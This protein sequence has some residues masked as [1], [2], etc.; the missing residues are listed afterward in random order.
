MEYIIVDKGFITGHGAVARDGRLP[1]G[2]VAVE[3]FCGRVGDS[4]E[5]YDTD[6]KRLSDK[7]LFSKGLLKIP[8]GFKWDEKE[9]KTVEMTL[10]EKLSAG[11]E[12]IPEGM[13]LVDGKLVCMSIEEKVSAGQ[14]TVQEASEEVRSL[15]DSLLENTD[16][17]MLPDFPIG[18]SERETVRK[19]RNMLRHLPEEE[20]FPFVEVPGLD[21]EE[22]MNGN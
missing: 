21:I 1:A 20:G 4:V 5:L 2:A 15:R 9:E 19:Y 12:K 18:D 13:K 7:A 3:N 16:K 17:Y 10:E 14:M 11:I 22:V 6:W 8:S